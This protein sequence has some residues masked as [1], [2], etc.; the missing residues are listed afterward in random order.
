MSEVPHLHCLNKSNVKQPA[1]AVRA[2][3]LHPRQPP[4]PDSI[5]CESTVKSVQSTLSHL[6]STFVPRAT[7]THFFVEHE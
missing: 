6:K 7:F 4:S 3:P 2:F 1:Q 5:Y